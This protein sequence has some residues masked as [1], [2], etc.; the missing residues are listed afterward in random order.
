[1]CMLHVNHVQKVV[2]AMADRCGHSNVD[3]II[4][5]P[6]RMPAGRPGAVCRQGN[7]GSCWEAPG[8]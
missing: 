5:K 8:I 4:S 1:M 2:A 6:H 7:L 3:T